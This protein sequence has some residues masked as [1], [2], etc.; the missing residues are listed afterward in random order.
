VNQE[1]FAWETCAFF[2]R[3]YQKHLDAKY[4][5]IERSRRSLCVSSRI[6]ISQSRFKKILQ[7][8]ISLVLKQQVQPPVPGSPV[9][10]LSG[11]SAGLGDDLH[12]W[13]GR[14]RAC[15]T[16]FHG[17]HHVVSGETF[18]GDHASLYQRI[19]TEI[20]DAFDSDVEKA[21]GVLNDE[22]VACPIKL[23]DTVLGTLKSYPSPSTLD[24]EGIAHTGLLI[25]RDHVS[26]L[27]ELFDK[28]ESADTL[29]LGLNDHLAAQ[30][31]TFESYVYLLQQ[32]TR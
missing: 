21:M 3:K 17:A 18:A 29:T 13:L 25:V 31:N 5:S 23:T 22:S 11:A 10:E 6:T 26:Y 27:E 20:E 24:S 14:V 28:L 8:E 15:M 16:W 9:E 32:R 2:L 19:Y 12:E 1:R 7:E 30:A 4:V